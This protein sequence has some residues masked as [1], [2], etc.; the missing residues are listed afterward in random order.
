MSCYAIGEQRPKIAKSCWIGPGAQV[1]GDVELGELVSVWPNAVIRGDYASIRIGTETNV[2]DCCVLHVDVGF[3]LEIGERVTIGHSAIL[4]GCT[5]ESEVLIGLG[6]KV[7]NGARVG[8]GS[9]IA[10]G[11]LVRAGEQIPPYSL[12]AGLPGVVKRTLPEEAARQE[13]LDSVARYIAMSDR[14]RKELSI[15]GNDD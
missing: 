12:V 3:P 8:K 10:A 6:S 14:Y 11:A 7:L 4:H 2:Q 5:I 15:L 13:Q 1:L 9:V